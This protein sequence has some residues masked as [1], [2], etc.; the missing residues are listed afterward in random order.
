MQIIEYLHLS[1]AHA[2]FSVIRHKLTTDII[3][4]GSMASPMAD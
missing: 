2:I 1:I 4:N 3:A